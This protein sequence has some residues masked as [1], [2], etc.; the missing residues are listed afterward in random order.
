MIKVKRWIG[1][2]LLLICVLVGVWIA[3]DNPLK[4]PV[5]LLGFSLLELPLGIW[6]LAAFLTGSVLSYV[7]GL[8]GSLS[9][10]AQ[11]RRLQRQLVH[12]ETEIKKLES[13]PSK[14]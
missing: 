8:P 13:A 4:V 12:A 7:I 14:N 3:Q 2:L 1:L 10:K 5:T 11:C 6:L 9:K